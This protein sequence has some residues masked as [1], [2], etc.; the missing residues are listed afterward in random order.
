MCFNFVGVVI[1]LFIRRRQ[2]LLLGSGTG[3]YMPLKNGA[4]RPSD[5][6]VLYYLLQFEINTEHIYRWHITALT[7]QCKYV[8][9]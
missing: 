3:F 2:E 8:G 1:H 5:S 7:C 9:L 4:S 6:Y